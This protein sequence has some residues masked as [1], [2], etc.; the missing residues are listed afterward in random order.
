MGILASLLGAGLRCPVCRTR[1]TIYQHGQDKK[2]EPMGKYNGTA[3]CKCLTCGTC[4]W[5]G[6]VSTRAMTSSEAEAMSRARQRALDQL[7]GH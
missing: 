6:L 4:L 5:V 1:A 7:A 2:W 3:V